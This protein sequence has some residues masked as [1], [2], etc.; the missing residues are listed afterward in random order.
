MG[1]AA[2]RVVPGGIQHGVG[3]RKS[4]TRSYNMGVSRGYDRLQGFKQHSL[5][6]SEGGSR[7]ER[8]HVAQARAP[9]EKH[10][11]LHGHQLP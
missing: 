4:G 2:G 9:G 10:P 8:R 6:N 11:H 3:S 7:A 5:D 1:W